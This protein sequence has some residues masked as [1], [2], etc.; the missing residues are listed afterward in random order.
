MLDPAKP[1]NFNIV[2]VA[3]FLLS[4]RPSRKFRA[5]FCVPRRGR[6]KYARGHTGMTLVLWLKKLKTIL[7]LFPNFTCKTCIR[8][9]FVLKSLN[10]SETSPKIGGIL[11]V[12][13]CGGGGCF[14]SDIATGCDPVH[15]H[16]YDRPFHHNGLA[17]K[18]K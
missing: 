3:V 2:L 16:A 6:L 1:E 4:L 11:F 8:K 12:W 5:D 18:L 10:S 15:Y 13:G 7:T 14:S 9:C 17:G